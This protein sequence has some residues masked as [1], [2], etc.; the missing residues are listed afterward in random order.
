MGMAEDHQFGSYSRV[1]M[2]FDFSHEPI[3]LFPFLLEQLEI[4]F[5]TQ[6]ICRYFRTNPIEEFS[7]KLNV[8]FFFVK[9]VY[10]FISKYPGINKFDPSSSIYSNQQ[11]ISNLSNITL[12]AFTKLPNLVQKGY[13]R[14]HLSLVVIDRFASYILLTRSDP[15]SL[16]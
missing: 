6:H 7:D 15:I 16:D 5:D 4:L 1:M 9:R 8:I 3:C 10:K 11:S 13:T 2:I 12:T 14:V